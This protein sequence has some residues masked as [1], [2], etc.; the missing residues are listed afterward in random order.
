MRNVE[1]GKRRVIA[2]IDI[3]IG[4]LKIAKYLVINVIVSLIIR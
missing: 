3:N 1:I 4:W 2:Q